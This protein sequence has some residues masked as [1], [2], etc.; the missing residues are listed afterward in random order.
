[1]SQITNVEYTDHNRSVKPHTML[2]LNGSFSTNINNMFYPKVTDS[3]GEITYN[4]G[5]FSW[6]MDGRIQGDYTGYKWVSFRLSMYYR[7]GKIVYEFNNEYYEIKLG[8]RDRLKYFE[9]YKIFKNNNILSDFI[10]D[11]LFEKSNRTVIG[12]LSAVVLDEKG[13]EQRRIGNLKQQFNPF[14][15][16]WL[17]NGNA[18]EHFS[19]TFNR[20]YGCIVKADPFDKMKWGIYLNPYVMSDKFDIYIGMRNKIDYININNRFNK[21]VKIERLEKDLGLDISMSLNYKTLFKY[22]KTG[23]SKDI[24][25]ITRDVSAVLTETR[26][27]ESLKIEVIGGNLIRSNKNIFSGSMHGWSEICNN[28]SIADDNITLSKVI[29]VI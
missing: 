8:S 13:E 11:E 4:E 21:I 1:M 7:R 19:N 26:Y 16:N 17:K 12:F 25:N 15:G 20:S 2:Y 10:L 6:D 14:G 3:I 28:V 5:A 22:E 23:I 24:S 18:E 9:L 29:F 27:F